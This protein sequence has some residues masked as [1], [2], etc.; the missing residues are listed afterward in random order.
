MSINNTWEQLMQLRGLTSTTGVLHEAQVL[1]L[2]MWP[3]VIIGESTS[4][5]FAF[6]HEDR[7]VEFAISIES[8]AAPDL[9]KRLSILDQSVKEL[10]GPEYWVIVRKKGGKSKV[11]LDSPGLAP[12]R[13]SPK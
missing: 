4:S 2:Q 10:L 9:K 7:I 3:R 6:S 12:V 1:Q 8:T 5:E 13:K 11:L